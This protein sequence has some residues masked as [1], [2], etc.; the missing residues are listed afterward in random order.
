MSES[1]LNHGSF[2]DKT[3]EDEE[4]KSFFDKTDED[5]ED[6]SGNSLDNLLDIAENIEKEAKNIQ[7]LVG[8]DAVKLA[9]KPPTESKGENPTAHEVITTPEWLDLWSERVQE[10][11]PEIKKAYH[12]IASNLKNAEVKTEEELRNFLDKAEPE[13]K[14]AWDTLEPKLESF[15]HTLHEK[16]N[17]LE[18][19]IRDQLSRSFKKLKEII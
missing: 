16:W 7:N 6:F 19:K 10:Y 9:K 4:E 2:F 14:K 17:T 18:P 3:D 12:T 11:P 15:G 1:L 5:E 8:S 13:V